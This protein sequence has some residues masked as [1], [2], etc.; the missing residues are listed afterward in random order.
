MISGVAL[1]A[2]YGLGGAIVA[3]RWIRQSLEAYA[4]AHHTAVR[5]GEIRCNPF[6]L[7]VRFGPLSFLS[8]SGEPILSI[9]QA[10]LTFGWVTFLGRS[11]DLQD[12]DV[13][14]QSAQIVRSAGGHV[15]LWDLLPSTD[16]NA[17][18]PAVS[19]KRSRLEAQ[20]LVYSQP[21]DGPEARVRIT[22]LVLANDAFSTRST[23][24][25]WTLSIRTD[26]DESAEVQAKL[27]LEPLGFGGRINVHD[28]DLARLG[29]EWAALARAASG[30]ASG[31]AKIVWVASDGAP[32]LSI[33]DSEVQ[34]AALS[35]ALG[36]EQGPALNVAHWSI[37]QLSYEGKTSQLTVDGVTTDSPKLHLT[38]NG[39]GVVTSSTHATPSTVLQLGS[40]A[41]QN[42][43]VVV[44]DLTLRRPTTI[45]ASAI[46]LHVAGAQEGRRAI[47]AQ[48]A[49]GATGHLEM[50]GDVDVSRE[51]ASL[52]IQATGIAIT[53]YNAY[54]EPYINLRIDSALGATQGHFEQTSGS[55]HYKGE[56][57]LDE[58]R[59]HDVARKRDLFGW[60]HLRAE[61]LAVQST[62]TTVH[63]DSMRVDAPYADVR[64]DE[65]GKINLSSILRG[66]TEN[67][68]AGEAAIAIDTLQ[69]T[70]GRLYFSDE[71]QRPTFTTGIAQLTG[72]IDHL[73]SDPT[74]RAHLAFNGYVDRY[75]PVSI[76]GDANFL[77]SPVSADVHMHFDNLELT[78]LSPY[79]G[80]FAGYRIR[81][82]KGTAD[83]QY[84]IDKH[85]VNASH[86]IRLKQ[87]ELGDRVEGQGDFGV[88][89]RLVVALLKDKDGNIDLDVPLT[90]SFSDPDFHLGQMTR[91]VMGN[92][93]RKVATAPFAF[94]G[95]LFGAGE[96]ISLIDFPAGSANLSATAR[97]RLVTL[98]H[99]MQARPNVNLEVPIATAQADIVALA[100]TRYTSALMARAR[101]RFGDLDDATLTNRMEQSPEER[102][103]VLLA[104]LGNPAAAT[105][106]DT[107]QLDIRARQLTTP[108]AEDLEQLARAR[109]ESI[110]TALVD[111]TGVDPGRIFLVR[112]GPAETRGAAIQLRLGLR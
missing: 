70:D 48:A 35:M 97:T 16:P 110:Q 102:R 2:L 21:A 18:W 44:D 103:A 101:E 37:G 32:H 109:A 73:S 85:Q 59:T 42:G 51:I 72:Q 105:Q 104:M 22:H 41:I 17:P 100:E 55:W 23:G 43:E 30:R 24:S 53:D 34:G 6:T 75:A 65:G 66:E 60:G 15:N 52:D 63:V 28:F 88:P 49:L 98:T 56:A 38:R 8:T 91:K 54:I 77:G 79:S 81:K 92:L 3:P 25:D 33:T 82:G 31:H 45:T 12:V 107:A 111:G 80:R 86:H 57:T 83:L 84:H 29:P 108:N 1:S 46:Q 78:G 99:A 40:L 9:A 4:T 36:P 58:V 71:S 50:T 26:R 74:T 11:I 89:L 69:L 87:F 19:I 106:D 96:E 93:F 5:I 39:G 76:D 67:S 27:S 112:A 14:I 62:D 90:G 61:G 10:R 95:S 64:I 94:L 47:T 7:D 68:P 13:R 20:D